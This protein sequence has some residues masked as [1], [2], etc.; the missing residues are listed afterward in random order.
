[1]HELEGTLNKTRTDPNWM[2]VSSKP[3]V[4]RHRKWHQVPVKKYVLTLVKVQ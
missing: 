1:M 3:E 2:G 4:E